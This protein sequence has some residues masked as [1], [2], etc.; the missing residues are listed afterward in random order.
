[1]NNF[2]DVMFSMVTIVNNKHSLK[3]AKRIDLKSSHHKRKIYNYG[4]GY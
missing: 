2:G 1:M 3:V 4:D